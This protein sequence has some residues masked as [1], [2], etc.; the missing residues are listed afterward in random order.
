MMTNRERAY[1]AQCTVQIYTE[2]LLKLPFDAA[3]EENVI[4]VLSDLRH[5]CDLQGIN[6]AHVLSLSKTHYEQ[7]KEGEL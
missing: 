1:R 6:F 3:S 4:D 2:Q 5:F 7:E